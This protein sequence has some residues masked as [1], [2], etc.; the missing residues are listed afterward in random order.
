MKPFLVKKAGQSWQEVLVVWLFV[1]ESMTGGGK[2][3]SAD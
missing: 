1:I 3:W 2:D